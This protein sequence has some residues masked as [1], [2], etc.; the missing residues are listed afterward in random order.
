MNSIFPL[1]A[2]LFIAIYVS[3]NRYICF[4]SGSDI[5]D[6]AAAFKCDNYGFNS[7]LAGYLR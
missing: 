1:K 4:D 5:V 6:S 7:T 3:S 2:I